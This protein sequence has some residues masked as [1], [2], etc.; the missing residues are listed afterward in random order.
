[1]KRYIYIEN[2]NLFKLS[3]CNVKQLLQFRSV[4]IYTTRYDIDEVSTYKILNM[5]QR[6][7]FFSKKRR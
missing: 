1:M 6:N 5:T 3:W 2:D 4:S 7:F